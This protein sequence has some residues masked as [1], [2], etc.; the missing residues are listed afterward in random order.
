MAVFAP[1]PQDPLLRGPDPQDALIQAVQ[2]GDA[3]AA[4]R[5]LQRWVHRRGH[6]SLEPLVA[7][8]ASLQGPAAA[9]WLRRQL[10]QPVAAS[11]A[12]AAVPQVE[13]V[14]E[15]MTEQASLAEPPAGPEAEVEP[16]AA[17]ELPPLAFELPSFELPQLDP[18]A[19]D[20][21]AVDPLPVGASED[22]AAEDEPQE[23][24]VSEAPVA[25]DPVV[26]DPVAFDADSALPPLPQEWTFDL[27]AAFPPLGTTPPTFA[28]GPE[29]SPL[30]DPIGED[31]HEG[32]DEA[33]PAPATLRRGAFARMK[34]LVRGYLEEARDA[35]HR[36]DATGF[37]GEEEEELFE[38][39]DSEQE[40]AQPAHQAQPAPAALPE[41]PSFLADGAAAPPG[42]APESAAPAPSALSDLRS[43]LPEA[44]DQLPRA[45]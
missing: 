4:A 20:P 24:E 18:P 5:H 26:S 16:P 9:D 40:P 17:L 33:A 27:E 11:T 8:V 19:L 15:P 36:F 29:S 31:E 25:S 42:R 21:P 34:S 3:A 37:D 39:D 35:L 10:E 43:W 30:S 7:R 12:S 32:G 41:I 14:A 1:A 45:S 38:E 22:A 6:A 23:F 2:A 28:S 13:A 44:D